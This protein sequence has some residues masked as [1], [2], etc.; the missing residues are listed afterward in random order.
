MEAKVNQASM[1]R[2]IAIDMH[3]IE[4]MFGGSM[5]RME[6]N[7]I[8]VYTMSLSLTDS[9]LRSELVYP[10]ASNMSVDREEYYYRHLYCGLFGMLM[11][12]CAVSKMQRSMT[13]HLW[14]KIP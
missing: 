10:Y 9:V 3:P 1:I 13:N 12:T 11:K 6:I 4:G 8:V 5:C 14:G 7:L 2:N